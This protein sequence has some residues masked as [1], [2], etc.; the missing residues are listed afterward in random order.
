MKKSARWTRQQ[1]IDGLIDVIFMLIFLLC[2]MLLKYL[3]ISTSF[4]WPILLF[5]WMINGTL[6]RKRMFREVTV[7][8]E[9]LD[10]PVAELRK[11]LGFGSYDLTEWDEKRTLISL[12]NLY[13]LVDYVE[14]RYFL[15]FHEHYNKEAAAKK[16]AEKHAAVVSE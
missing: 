13:R 6:R 4:L 3:G 15:A 16:L 9:L 11:V 2:L 14:E 8:M 7:I 12:P 1:K 10:I 5:P